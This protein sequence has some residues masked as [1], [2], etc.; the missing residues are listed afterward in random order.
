MVQLAY[1]TINADPT[2]KLKSK[3]MFTLKRIKR[4]TNIEE[5]MYRIMYPTSCTAPNSMGY[6]KS[7]KLVP[8]QA[9]CV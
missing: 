9:N 7:I 5:G 8:P 1:R 3:L 4:E 6:K 2:N